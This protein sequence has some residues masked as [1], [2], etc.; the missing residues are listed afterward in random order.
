LVY[1][2]NTL[3]QNVPASKVSALYKNSKTKKINM[4]NVVMKLESAINNHFC[5]F[6]PSKVDF[7]SETLKVAPVHTYGNSVKNT[8]EPEFDESREYSVSASIHDESP[9]SPIRI[10]NAVKEYKN[11][12]TS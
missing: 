10:S 7:F 8:K 5:G 4:G 9:V 2:P 6:K 3:A 1:N 12:K 11:I